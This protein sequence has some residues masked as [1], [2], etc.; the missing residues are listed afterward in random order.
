MSTKKVSVVL[1]IYVAICIIIDYLLSYNYYLHVSPSRFCM[2]ESNREIVQFL[3]NGN[4]PVFTI[5][6]YLFVILYIGFGSL[7]FFKPSKKEFTMDRQFHRL[8]FHGQWLFV[9]GVVFIGL[10]LISSG[11]TW[12]YFSWAYVIRD[13]SIFFSL[14]FLSCSVCIF[15]LV[16]IKKKS[17]KKKE[18]QGCIIMKWKEFK[19]QIKKE[20]TPKKKILTLIIIAIAA[21]QIGL[22]TMQ[23]C[24]YHRNEEGY[25]NYCCVEMSRDCEQ[26]FESIG[27]HV[28][29]MS[30]KRETKIENGE[31]GYKTDRHQWILLDFGWFQIP[32]ESTALF[33]NNPISYGYDHVFISEGYVV[34]GEKM[35]PEGWQPYE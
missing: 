35:E 11:S 27:I 9:S 12:Y 2:F 24:R 22:T 18:G 10:I 3:D 5:L 26:F 33:P 34:N 13:I 23:V 1:S 29:Q 15:T 8:I 17:Y 28:Y 7:F 19:K 16:D 21:F 30:G 20:I 6:A 31:G 4:I 32:Y 25:E 14:F